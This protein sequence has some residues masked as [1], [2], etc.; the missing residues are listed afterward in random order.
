MSH[1]LNMMNRHPLGM[2]AACSLEGREETVEI[3]LATQP[4]DRWTFWCRLH[5][6]DRCVFVIE[7]PEVPAD[8]RLLPQKS[9]PGF[10]VAVAHRLLR[11]YAVQASAHQPA[12]AHPSRIVERHHVLGLSGDDVSTLPV[13]TVDDTGLVRGHID[14]KQSL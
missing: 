13:R 6:V 8:D 4:Y 10:V 3:G 12:E 11:H 2:N 1:P 5:R 14:S 9:A 7:R